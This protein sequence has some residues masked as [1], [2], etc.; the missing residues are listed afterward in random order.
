VP[1]RRSP[2]P[3]GP[4]RAL[5]LRGLN[6]QKARRLARI[7]VR[8]HSRLGIYPGR[9]PS[10]ILRPENAP[11][12]ASGSFAR[13][14]AIGSRIGYARIQPLRRPA[15]RNRVR[16]GARVEGRRWLSVPLSPAVLSYDEVASAIALW[17]SRNITG[18][19]DAR[20]SEVSN[21]VNPPL[22]SSKRGCRGHYADRNFGGDLDSGRRAD[23]PEKNSDR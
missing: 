14:R 19:S 7:G 6:D 22:F 12:A 23:S 5:G 10:G 9:Q 13:M 1:V 3:H 21:A 15:S 16:P 17:T 2:Q 18:L 4:R 11:Y 20:F 8:W